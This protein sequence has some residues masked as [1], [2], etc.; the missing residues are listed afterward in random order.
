[1]LRTP[2]TLF[3]TLL[4]LAVSGCSDSSD[5]NKDAGADTGRATDM[6]RIEGPI[7]GKIHDLAIM[8]DWGQLMDQATDASDGQGD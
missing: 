1:M 6:R 3:V 4:M 7:T 2:F 8:P 5:E